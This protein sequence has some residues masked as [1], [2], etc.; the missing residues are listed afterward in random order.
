MTE[1]AKVETEPVKYVEPELLREAEPIPSE[2]LKETKK[3]ANKMPAKKNIEAISLAS[4]SDHGLNPES[5]KPTP[6]VTPQDIKKEVRRRTYKR[7]E[8][9]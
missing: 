1:R 6:T 2:P 9:S 8:R 4:E 5:E 3:K 7:N